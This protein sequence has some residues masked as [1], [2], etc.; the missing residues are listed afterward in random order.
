MP[1]L[2]SVYRHRGAG[3]PLVTR[4]DYEEAGGYTALL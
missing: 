4:A 1:V 2:N 3:S